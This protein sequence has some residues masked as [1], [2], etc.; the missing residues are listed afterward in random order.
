ML[1]YWVCYTI[2]QSGNAFHCVKGQ[3]YPA[4]MRLVRRIINS[5]ADQ[6]AQKNDKIFK[7]GPVSTFLP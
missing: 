4:G 6:A 3:I 5:K 7:S 2:E 1:S